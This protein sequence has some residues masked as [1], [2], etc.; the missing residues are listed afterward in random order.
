MIT[1]LLPQ[2]H[3]LEPLEVTQLLPPLTLLSALREVAASPLVLD[4][5]LIPLLLEPCTTDSAR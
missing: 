1:H 4:L 3:N 5:V 2:S